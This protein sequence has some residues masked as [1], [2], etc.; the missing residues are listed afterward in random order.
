MV[1]V[2][3]KTD[4]LDELQLVTPAVPDRL[5]AMLFLAALVHGVL[6]IGVTFNAELADRFANVIALEV[7]IVA[8]PDQQIDRPDD[9]EYLAQ[10][11]QEGGGNTTEQV[12]AS[13]PLQS[14]MTV[15][16]DGT[17]DGTALVDADTHQQSADEVLAS[18]D[19]SDRQVEIEPRTDPQTEN[20]IAIVMEAGN[21]AT[22]PLPQEDPASMLIHADEPRQ[23]IISADTRES[24]IATYLDNWKRRIE[25]VGASYLPQLGDLDNITGSPTLMVRI[26]VTGELLEAVIRKSSGSTILDLAAL[27]IL[28]RASPFNPFPPEISAE[29]DTVRFEYKW[30]FAGQLVT[31]T[32]DAD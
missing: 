19:A 27:D 11:S 9:A 6:I 18:Q 13:A 14:A 12:R 28:Q 3:L 8:N 2:V 23:L 1:N 24:V 22:L 16:N 26:D 5:P 30:L 32:R 7:T 31:S 25:A 29:Y 4:P 10:A 20:S 15:D 17:E 21:E